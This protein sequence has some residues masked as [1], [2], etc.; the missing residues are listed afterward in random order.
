M[1]FQSLI[2]TAFLK[3]AIQAAI[4]SGMP[5]QY[6]SYLLILPLFIALIAAARHLLGLTTYGILVPA[7]IALIWVQIGLWPG[8]VFFSFLFLWSGIGRFIS[9]KTMVAKFR[10]NYLPRMAIL[11]LFISLAI[12][13]LGLVSVFRLNLNYKEAIFPLL[14]LVLVVQ[15]LIETEITLSKKES[16]ALVLETILL[17][18]IGYFLF[19]WPLLQ[20]FAL[21]HPGLL[22]VLT[23][24]FSIGVGRYTGFR[25]LERYRFKSIVEKP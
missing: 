11:L 23:L 2:R 10:I 17:A 20:E 6:F 1:I 18:F 19:S 7:I 13:A 8:I 24:V 16:Q 21:L 22:I 25:L 3:D 12:F 15:D 9:K 4:E 14:A 5:A